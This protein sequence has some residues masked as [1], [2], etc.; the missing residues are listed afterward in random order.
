MNTPSFSVLCLTY[1]RTKHLQN[2]IACFLA[3]D[4]PGESELLIFNSCPD[5]FLMLE[6]PKITVVNCQTRP[7]NLGQCRNMAIHQCKHHHILVLDDDDAILSNHLSNFARAFTPGIEWVWHSRQFYSAGN[8]IKDCVRGTFNVVGFTRKA[9]HEAGKYSEMNTGEDRNFVGR[10]TQKC[11]GV[12]LDLKP[13]EVSGIYVWGQGT[14]HI[15]GQGDDQPGRMSSYDRAAQDLARR[16]RNGSEP[17]GTIHL[18]PEFLT[19]WQ[20]SA[21][22]YLSRNMQ[23]NSQ[24]CVVCL[25]RYGDLIGILP[26]LQHINDHYGKPALMVSREFAG[27]LEG[28]GYVDPVIVDLKNN[29]LLPALD[30]ARKKFKFVINAQV[31]GDGFHQE[32]LTESFN[33]EA[34]FQCGMLPQFYNDAMR[35]VFDRRDTKRESEFMAK[36]MHVDGRPMIAVAL[37]NSVSSPWSGGEAIQKAIEREFGQTH[38]IYDLQA[39]RATVIYDLLGVLESSVCLVSVDTGMLH[40]AAATN[41][42][43]VALTNP[44]EWLG[45]IPRCNLID[46]MSYEKATAEKVLGSI[47]F[48]LEMPKGDFKFL[49]PATSQPIR[50]IFHAV[51]MHDNAPDARKIRAWNSWDKLYQTGA[52]IPAHY[53]NY[54]RSAADI[55]DP[56]NLPYLKDVLANAMEMAGDDDILFFT[57][58]DICVHPELPEALRFYAGVYK[59]VCSRRCEWPRNITPPNGALTPKAWAQKSKPH[60]GRDLFAFTKDWLV[61][62]W[63]EIGDSILAASDWDLHLAALIRHKHGIITTRKNLEQ[64]FFPAEIPLGY[65]GH[66]AHENE[67]SKPANVNT[68]PSQRHNRTLF[69]AWA[70]DALPDLVFH[71]GDVI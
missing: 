5:Q 39:H 8:A 45:S 13:E 10:L 51:E 32:R 12:V 35:P 26:I 69:K 57:N 44:K 2:A 1:G 65:I 67:W 34:W 61:R 38:N 53:W 25:G 50:K 55:G 49:Q 31:W 11:K 30:M 40:L 63:D 59:A 17:S 64:D 14:Y 43:T 24:V 46:C 41:V 15:S 22:D 9:W 27:L 21:K 37:R 3:Q 62:Y 19:D 42:W 4:Y 7:D 71:P 23:T 18:K 68:A 6:H 36:T 54:A 28:V 70:K 20:R 29:Q 33:M 47:R 16:L 56:R 48:A 60:M 58:D 66:E 52:V